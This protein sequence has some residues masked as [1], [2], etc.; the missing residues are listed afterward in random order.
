MPADDRAACAAPTTVWAC[1]VSGST[2][3]LV[4]SQAQ[5]LAVGNTVTVNRTGTTALTGGTVS[6]VDT[7]LGLFKYIVTFGSTPSC[8]ASGVSSVVKT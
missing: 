3:V 6:A 1:S 8:G 7:S 2:L 4:A 5:N